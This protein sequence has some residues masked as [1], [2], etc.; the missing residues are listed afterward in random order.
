[1]ARHRRRDY[2]PQEGLDAQTL[3]TVRD[4]LLNHMEE[5]PEE[6]LD[7]MMRIVEKMLAEATD[8]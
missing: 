6:G 4:T 1:M 5:N 2:T 3:K 8:G 7:A